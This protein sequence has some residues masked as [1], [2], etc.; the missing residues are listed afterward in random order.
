MLRDPI[1]RLQMVF[2]V[3]VAVA[4]IAIAVIGSNIVDR[5]YEH[6]KEIKQ[7]KIEAATDD[8]S[9]EIVKNADDA[10]T[11]LSRAKGS[12][13]E[14]Y[15]SDHTITRT[16]LKKLVDDKRLTRFKMLR[17]DFKSED[18]EVLKDSMVTA[19]RLSDVPV[20]KTLIDALVAMPKLTTIEMSRCDIAKNALMNLAVS[21]VRLLRIKKCG[22]TEH[23]IFT[24]ALANDLARMPTLIHADLSKN[25][26]ADQS[27]YGLA[28]AHC[29]VL[30]IARTNASDADLEILKHLPRLQ[31]LEVDSCAPITCQ[32]LKSVAQSIS[33]KHV[34]T[35]LPI[36]SCTFPPATAI[37]FQANL[38][39]IPEDMQ[40]ENNIA[41]RRN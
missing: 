14:L 23:R 29:Q 6:V 15:F 22:E 7:T 11:M 1:D 10:K 17:C 28:G 4:A 40:F 35:D 20:D 9:M 18:F 19:I 21:K 13:N 24:Q 30:S 8:I 12:A 39:R 34:H 31:Y 5:S 27:L 16:D 2:I 38:F 41:K 37:K 26:F 32:G 25:S 36:S 3:I 33:L